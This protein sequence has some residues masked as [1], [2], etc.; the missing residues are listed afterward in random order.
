MRLTS[1]FWTAALM[2]QVR[3]DGAFAYLVRRGA[4][5]AGAIFIEVRHSDGFLDLYGPAPQSLY[6]DN[7]AKDERLF[8]HLASHKPDAEIVERLEKEL[9]FDSDIWLIEIE[10]LKTETLPFKVISS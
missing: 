10:G 8:V 9:R 7:A 2:R 3:A 1:D 4:L 6:E 5:E